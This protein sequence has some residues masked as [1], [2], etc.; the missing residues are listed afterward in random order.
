MPDPITGAI[1]GGTQLVGGLMSGREARRGQER[2]AN[3]QAQAEREGM[4]QL[5]ADLAPYN[6]LGKQAAPL[7][8]QSIWGGGPAG[9]WAK[10]SSRD[11]SSTQSDYS[12]LTAD[13]LLSDPFFNALSRQQENSLLQERAALGLG[14]SGGTMDAMN[15]NLLL[16]GND[17]RQ[18]HLSN[19]LTQNQ[20]RFNQLMGITG[21][22]QASAAQTGAQAY[23]SG[24]NIGQLNSVSP[25]ARAQ[26]RSNMFG[27]IGNLA[28]MGMMAYGSGMFNS[29][30]GGGSAV[31]GYTPGVQF[32]AG[33]WMG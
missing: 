31:G 13:Q 18:Q 3:I 23:Q 1:I 20:A 4:A 16:L 32:N 30:V 21:M 2:A 7:L 33:Q 25:L 27:T 29:P 9:G 12:P 14:S 19:A 15:R 8:M 6:Q 5:R 22:G 28:G 26:E 24:V 17:F 10:M 11:G